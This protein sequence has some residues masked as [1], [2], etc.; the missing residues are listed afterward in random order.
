MKLVSAK[1]ALPLSP[2][3]LRRQLHVLQVHAASLA[4]RATSG[5]ARLLHIRRH[6]LTAGA[7]SHH[8]LVFTVIG[9]CV[10]RSVFIS[11]VVVRTGF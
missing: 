4:G 5:E 11:L 9:Q 3:A 2:L 1:L 6:G 10:S 7:H 8:G